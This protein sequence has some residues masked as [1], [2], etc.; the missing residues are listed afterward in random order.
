MLFEAFVEY[1]GLYTPGGFAATT[2]KAEQVLAR[3]R[4]GPVWLAFREAKV[5]GTVAAVIKGR[6]AYMRGMAVLPEA[7][8]LRVGSR[9]LEQVEEWA[10]QE[11]CSR[12][13]LS[14]TPFLGV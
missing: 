13:F 4:E 9:L 8:G 10:A 2:L 1:E 12:I 5:L 3:M 7:R 14:T 11:G 6:S